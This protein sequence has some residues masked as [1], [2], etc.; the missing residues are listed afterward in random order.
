MRS[1]RSFVITVLLIATCVAYAEA[2]SYHWGHSYGNPADQIVTSMM[3][4]DSGNVFMTG[5]FKDTID[6]GGGPLVYDGPVDCTFL[7]KIDAV[8]NHVWSRTLDDSLAYA[9]NSFGIDTNSNVYFAND[10]RN[11][12]DLGG[13]TVIAQGFRDGVIAKFDSNGNHIWTKTFGGTNAQVLL[14]AAA[15]DLAGNV[16]VVGTFTGTIDF[17][18]EITLTASPFAVNMFV[19]RYS[20]DGVCLW[21]E[22]YTGGLI[23]ITSVAVDVSGNTI[24]TGYHGAAFDFGG[25]SLHTDPYN[26]FLAKYSVT[27][28]HVWSRSFGDAG[29]FEY[30]FDVATDLYGNIAITGHFVNPF[31]LG[32]GA[33]ISAGGWDV[34]VANFDS[35]GN[36]RWSRSF[37]D[38]QTQRG[39]TVAMHAL[40]EVI[41]GGQFWGSVDFGGG[42]LSAST[43]DYFVAQY[44]A[45]GGHEWSQAFDVQNLGLPS[46]K[47]HSISAAANLSGKMSF[48]GSFKDRIDC[49][50]GDLMGFGGWD[51]F[52]A[53][54]GNVATGI[55]SCRVKGSS[56]RVYPNPFNPQTTATYSIPRPGVVHLRIYDVRGRHVRTLA[57]REMIAGEHSTAWDGRDGRGRQVAS[58]VYFLRLE[59]PG[60]TL[61]NRIVL[62]K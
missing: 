33:L 47:A 25:G 27:G 43:N 53:T 5:V 38:T 32:G 41:V 26:A 34:Y 61:T 51:P 6:F 54:F 48:V 40:G 20:M 4:D 22:K 59:S 62:L 19:A 29:T 12:V 1:R 52:V 45:D 57:E 31:D 28:D 42:V 37:G 36:H 44:D 56:L 10:F 30:A 55:T 23:V 9:V 35:N 58:G 46:D 13:G 2:T 49:G 14:E 15:A 60:G 50:G 8:G 21:S 7:A 39:Y 11:T 17:G 18:D 16:S 3:I 24:V